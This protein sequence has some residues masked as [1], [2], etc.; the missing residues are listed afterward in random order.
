MRQK[1]LFKLSQYTSEHGGVLLLKKRRKVAR[2]LSFKNPLKLVLKADIPK[3]QT[4]LRHRKKIEFC[5]GQFAR[6]FG[7]RIYEKAIA[8]DHIHF[9]ALF[10]SRPEYNQFIRALTGSLALV[11]KL[12]WK[13]RPW[14]RIVSWGKA[15]KI[16]INYIKQNHLEAIGEIPY[17]P[18]K[19]RNFRV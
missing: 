16:A 4:L 12:K 19:R 7:V 8:R 3:N 9:I 18:R 11:L 10:K 2:P 1:T 5:F 13:L 6:S 15:F 17:R 14:S